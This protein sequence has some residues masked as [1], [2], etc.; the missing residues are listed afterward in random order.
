PPV[1]SQPAADAHAE[2]DANT[3]PAG[4]SARPAG[5]PA[6]EELVVVA[7]AATTTVGAVKPNPLEGVGVLNGTANSSMLPLELPVDWV[8]KAKALPACMPVLSLWNG[9]GGAPQ[10]MAANVV[11]LPVVH[12]AV[13]FAVVGNVNCRIVPLSVEISRLPSAGQMSI[14]AGNGPALVDVSGNWASRNA[15]AGGTIG[16][17]GFRRNA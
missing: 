14:P 3:S 9:Q 12:S 17:P 7:F 6:V 13:G 2:V 11:R 16:S 8:T 15:M 5:L 1:G 10:E 4:A